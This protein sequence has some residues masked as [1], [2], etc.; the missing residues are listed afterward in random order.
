MVGFI[1]HRANEVV[2]PGVDA[3]KY[4]CGGLFHHI[5]LNDKGAGFTDEIFARLEPKFKGAAVLGF[6]FF[7]GFCNAGSEEMHIGFLVVI[8]VSYFE[9]AAE[10][11]KIDAL[12][13]FCYAEHNIKTLEENIYILDLAAGVHMEALHVEACSFHNALY[14]P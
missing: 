3:G 12:K 8:F 4:C 6:K 14:M 7:G 13:S 5:C 2:E 11:Y 1:K 9:P 10:V